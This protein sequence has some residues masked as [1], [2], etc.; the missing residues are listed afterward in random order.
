MFQIADRIKESSSSTGTGSVTLGGAF[1][2]FTSFLSGIGDGNST[3][4]AIENF[5]R[6][7]VGI[8]TYSSSTNSLSRDVVLES[9][10]GGAKIDLLGPS[11]VFCTLPSSK[12]FVKN[13]DNNIG[14]IS[15][16][17]AESGIFNTLIVKDSFGYT[18]DHITYQSISVA[19]EMRGSGLLTL[20]LPEDSGCFIHAHRGTLNDTT[21]ALHMNDSSSP[22]WK[23]GL[24][25]NPNNKSVVPSY[26]Y[27][28][29]LDGAAG[30]TA[31]S[32]NY[33]EMSTSAGFFTYHDSHVLLRASSAT[34]VYIDGK[35]N[36]YPVLTVQA[37]PTPA[38]DIQR[39]EDSTG[40]ILSKVDKAGTIS[41]VFHTS[42]IYFQDGTIQTTAGGGAGGLPEA[43]GAKI[44]QNTNDISTVSGLL[45]NDA[46]LSGY[47]ETRADSAD[48]GVATVS[49]IAVYASGQAE[50]GG[51]ALPLASGAKITANTTLINSVSGYYNAKLPIEINALIDGAPGTLDTLNEIA[52]AINDDANIAT[53]LTNSITANTT[54][55]HSSGNS[56]LGKINTVS[57]LLYNDAS[58]SG[59]FET[60]ADT[61]ATN[62]AT[63]ITN[64][65]SK[66]PA[67]SGAT[68]T[69][70]SGYFETR[71]DT[72]A[73]NIATNAT[74]IATNV[75]NIASKLPAASGAVITANSG[76]FEARSDQNASDIVVVSGLTGGGG[77]SDLDDLGDVSFGGTNLTRS[78][79]INAGPGGTPSHGTLAS[80]C[81]DNFAVGEN[82]LSNIT[83]AIDNIAI[84]REALGSLTDG[85]SNVA[86]GYL[87]L[88]KSTNEH[89]NNIAIGYLNQAYGQGYQNIAIGGQAM[90]GQIDGSSINNAY[91]LAI[92][93]SALMDI[94]TGDYNIALGQYALK[95]STDGSNSI[96][97]GK[98]ALQYASGTSDNIAIGTH[99]LRGVDGTTLT[100]NE[101]TLNT[102]VGSNAMPAM[103]TGTQNTAVGSSAGYSITTGD[104]NI[105]LGTQAGWGLTTESSML[106]IANDDQGSDGTLIKGDMAN[107]YLAVG[108]GDSLTTDDGDGCLQVYPL[109][110]NDKAIYSQLAVGHAGDAI[111]IED[112]AGSGLFRVEA[113]GSTSVSGLLTVESGVHLL[114][115]SP[116]TTTDKLYN[117]G[118]SLYFNGS[119]VG[120]GGGG[121]ISNV[122]EDTTPQLG[123]TLDANGQ[124]IDMGTNTITDT[125]VGQW[126][127]AYGWGDHSS[128]GYLT[129]QTSHTDVVV[130][131]DFGSNGILKR[132][133]A[134]AYGIVTDNSS[135]WD[136]AY[137]W[138]NHASAGYISATLTEDQVDDYVDGLLTAGSNVSLT[139]D[140]PA[141]TLTI[142]ATD[143]TYTKASFDLDHLFILVDASDDDSEHL[144]TFTGSTISDSVT[145][146]AALQ[147]LETAVETKTSNTGD[148]TGVDLT[149]GAGIT[150]DSET[151]TTS[152]D[153]S[154]TITCTV[155]DTNTQLSQD[156][157]EDFV[158]GVLTAG[159][160][161]S[162]TYDDTA[163][164]L[165]VAS[166]DTV[167]TLPEATATVKGGIELFS[168]TDQ[169]VAA[170]AVSTTAA[171]T[172]GLQL[173]SDGQ[174]VINVPWT[175][176]TYS[177]ATTSAE[178]L[179][180]TAHHDKLDG[181]EASATA[182]QSNA[183]IKTAIE[184]GTDIALGGNPTTTTQSAGNNST[185]IATTAYADAA[186][187]AVVDSAPG[188]LDTLNELAAAL[189]DDANYAST[190]TTALG[191]KAP[192]ASPTFTGTVAIPNISDLE[193]A[194]TANTAKVTNV[195]TDLAVTTSTTTV[196]VTSSDGTN[197]TIPVATTSVGGVMS[198]AMFDEHTANVAKNT[199]VST[200]LS[201][202]TVDATS[203][204]ITSDGGSDDIVLAQATTSV[205]G[206]LSAA[207]WN[208]IVA[209]TAKVTNVSTNLGITTSETTAIITSS[210]GDNATIPVATTS[211][212]G[213]MSKAL[214]DKLDGIETA[215]TAD[216]SNAEIVAAVE[217]GTDSNT[218]T[219]ADH[220]KLNGIE[221]SATADQSNAEIVA[222]VEAGTDSN[223]FTDADHSKLN[224]IEASATAD[225]TAGEILTLLEDGIDS[226]HYKDGSID[227]EHIA[228][229]AINSEHYAA[230]SIDAEHLAPDIISGQTEITSADADYL[231]VWDADDSALKKVDAG[232]FRG[233]GG[234]D[235]ANGSNN[236]IATFSDADSLNGEANFTFD[237]SAATIIGTLTVGVDDT[238]HDVKLFGATAGSYLEWDE[239]ADRL[240]LVQGAFV[241]QPV[242][243][244][245]GTN[246]G[247]TLQI[248]L[249]R[250]NYHNITLNGHVAVIEFQN[251]TIGQKFIIRFTQ[252][253]SAKTVFDTGSFA[254]RI[255]GSV[256]AELKWA[257]NV[258][259]TMST[260]DGHKDV[261]GFLC[262]ATGGSANDTKFDGF[263][264]GQDIPN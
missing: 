180:S 264:I 23:L 72:N 90:Y 107:K 118:G 191:L 202:G 40:K 62:I 234:V 226:V 246:S 104:K 199:N 32:N 177:E 224:A 88:W 132:T 5:N 153:Y 119:A 36:T 50:A 173:N 125:K 70:N 139:Y 45:Y 13:P 3:Y 87:A 183:E 188:T 4:Y 185:R 136:T 9:S 184:A 190:I 92:G 261:Y 130:D 237:G 197:A 34:G 82:S 213:V 64:I 228:D 121:G 167:Y 193:T 27:V 20:V 143:T 242:P 152:G 227:N 103:L 129:S 80:D 225:Q 131:G 216:Q 100:G 135:N 48:L 163:G 120:G 166:T 31:N 250:G 95:H 176:T 81:R 243:A 175:D 21:V 263:I 84:G 154:A 16:V 238:G 11:I 148:M 93:Y 252:A 221:A 86:L 29:G 196:I 171:R 97:I 59:Y 138:G 140:D 66:L 83:E 113:G 33:S 69:A 25:S 159:S 198:K 178:G 67:A 114:R 260:G 208:E 77:A 220:T 158:N 257:G 161:V 73:T 38:T 146:K 109:G 1:S 89:G 160:N 2:G 258:V 229:D 57:G 42:G 187:A 179:M 231:L 61:N 172:Y 214:F 256:A 63:N 207:K 115:S 149:A 189:G 245:G 249:S 106:F 219:D 212:G 24:K 47:F 174:G 147:A 76:Y 169:S 111:L 255:N 14:S 78:L 223:T 6:W 251:A 99:A 156:Q 110:V 186:V 247:T 65:A 49:G 133:G 236:R 75:T 53:T 200:A 253:S 68:I 52:A 15:G 170:T 144:G 58:L 192:I 211:V 124:T 233:G 8:G 244:T 74:N 168:D 205:A 44:T 155:T 239:S 51:N 123:G 232:E 157:V 126:D 254:A 134:G 91:N 98:S 54:L 151:N 150:I 128:G 79:L 209:N 112:S 108:K 222:A 56:L 96:A 240:H 35:S 230:G 117:V 26:G 217:A 141:G 262:T 203:Y 43:S 127:T 19:N 218:F 204:G 116:A 22:L 46:S 39:W 17:F 85:Y 259:P 55:I 10:S 248:D 37:A 182:D 164:T 137:G 60:R 102:A 145:I 194:V 105:F 7:E 71:T 235:A 165:T 195:S 12:T 162:L 122:V 94:T 142:A 241:N 28:Y 101:G 41:G 215:A 30:I 201:T 206:V 18:F 181:I 210:D